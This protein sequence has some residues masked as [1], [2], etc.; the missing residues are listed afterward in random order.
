MQHE[1]DN[2]ASLTQTAKRFFSGT[3]LSRISGV[4]RDM[5]MAAVFGTQ[6]SI[7]AFLV[8]FR[9]AH[10][11]R[12]VFGEGALQSAFIPRFE[13]LRHQNAE[14]ASL[15][16]RDLNAFL[17][18][19]LGILIT[20]IMVTIQG[21]LVVFEVS[22]NYREL[23]TL[24]LIM[25]PSLLFICLYG[26]NSS[27]LQCQKS[28][29]ISSV[30]PVAF[31]IAWIIG[32]FFLKDTATSLAMT[33]LAKWVIVASVVQWALTLPK[34]LAILR[35]EGLSNIW[36]SISLF[37]VDLRSLLKP[38]CLGIL[39]VTASQVNNALDGLFALYAE[40]SGP[41]FLWY[42]IRIQQLPLAL[43][44]LAISAALLP[45]LS[46]AFKAQNL[47]KSR[48]LLTFT[49][50]RCLALMIPMTVWLFVAGDVCVNVLYGR[51]DFN[52][53][54]LI[55][56]T[57]CLWAYASGLIPMTLIFIL[58]PLFY[59]QEKYR[60][61]TLASLV[62]MTLNISLN[63]LF[64]VGL[65]WGAESVAWSTSLSAWVNLGILIYAMA[66]QKENFLEDYL[67]T[68]LGKVGIATL[69]S[70][71]TLFWFEYLLSEHLHLGHS[72]YPRHF[73]EQ[74]IQVAQRA[75]AFGLPFL[76]TSFVL[77]LDEITGLF[78]R[79]LSLNFPFS[80][81]RKPRD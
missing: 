79:G 36:G 46:R 65:K 29:F 64:I 43:F 54:S 35:S 8:A 6:E 45:P 58:S 7:G 15:F 19:F 66:R 77:Q 17:V 69:M 60:I 30:A 50:S 53:H 5:A 49:L 75:L 27:L 32:L 12:R 20:I 72:I 2:Q 22:E 3:L 11:L 31:N 37:S 14:R 34:T 25:M 55:G 67:G 24:T 52:E 81:A 76:F 62:S 71:G 63:T 26:I 68:K 33:Q 41:A 23:L 1:P 21:A 56:T 74:F 13:Y 4:G 28:Y 9:L 44:G 38:L 57:H 51:G 73:S 48:E 59:A 47:S 39:G 10:L 61:P 78:Y 40:S 70:V 42:A 80:L 18:I 16:F